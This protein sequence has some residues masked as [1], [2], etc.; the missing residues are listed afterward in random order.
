MRA[1]EFTGLV[2]A[3]PPGD[4]AGELIAAIDTAD[5]AG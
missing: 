2:A 1:A 4:L 3:D 5:T